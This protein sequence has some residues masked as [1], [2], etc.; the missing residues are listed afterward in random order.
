METTEI[1]RKKAG[2]SLVDDGLFDRIP[3]QAIEAEMAVLGSV[4]IDNN[5]IGKVV[6][7]L[8]PD[9]FY[10]TAHR[11][12]YNAALTLFEKNEPVDVITLSNELKRVKVLEDVGGAYYLTQLVESVPTSANIEYHIRIVLEKFITRQLII[13]S[14]EIAKSC[15]EHVT[16]LSGLLDEAEQRIFNLT[17]KK[18]HKPYEHI[19]NTLHQTMEQIEEYHHSPDS[20]KGVP[21]GFE[22]LD[23]LTA[24]LQKSDLIIVAGRPSM[25]KTAFCLNIAKNTSVKYGNGIAIF[26]LEMSKE[27]L[28]FRLLCSEARV[29]AHK[30]RTGKLPESQWPKLSMVVGRLADAPIYIDDTPAITVLEIRSKTRRIALEH[31]LDLV[32]VDYLQLMQGPRNAESRQQ[33]ISHISRSLKALSKEI[34]VPIIALSQLSRAVESRPDKRPQLADLRESGAI[35][36]D[37]DIVMAIYRPEF[38]GV[39]EMNGISTEGKAELIVLKHRN[40]PTGSVYLT[41]DKRWA[42]FENLAHD[43]EV[44]F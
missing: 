40:G 18:L 22:H 3:P 32:I 35:E 14:A 1:K 5:C 27:Q 25:G 33:E 36:Q 28:A 8:I 34:N 23:E 4:M 2:K 17:Q 26:S 7:A 30:V 37:A 39:T 24:G 11:H 43:Q 19:K 31:K 42:S 16:D 29:D 9:S 20:I 6:E 21:T 12:I 15:Y 10:K 44:P 38:Y 13:E 41:F